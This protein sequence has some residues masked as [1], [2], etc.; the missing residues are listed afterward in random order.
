LEIRLRER[1]RSS[2]PISTKFYF[3]IVAVSGQAPR[4]LE[5]YALDRTGRVLG[6]AND[7]SG[8]YITGNLLEVQF[9][10]LDGQSVVQWQVQGEHGAVIGGNLGDADS[11]PGDINAEQMLEAHVRSVLMHSTVRGEVIGN[12]RARVFHQLQCSAARAMADNRRMPFSTPEK[13]VR[14]GYTP[15]VNCILGL[16][17]PQ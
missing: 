6:H 2:D 11:E 14:A 3:E 15:C 1:G 9:F 5:F 12:S 4:S 16:R 7:F 10:G 8:P 13:A 17:N